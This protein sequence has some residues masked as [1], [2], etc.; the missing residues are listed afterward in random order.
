MVT[1]RVSLLYLSMVDNIK[2]DIRDDIYQRSKAKDLYDLSKGL[3][4]IELMILP[5]K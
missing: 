1:L 2:D 3:E 5:N 4:I